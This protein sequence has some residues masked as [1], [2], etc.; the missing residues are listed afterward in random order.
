MSAK[1]NLFLPAGLVALLPAVVCAAEATG[2]RELLQPP[3]AV[4]ASPITDR[5]A[6][7]GIY[8]MPSVDMPM[9]Y[10][11][12]SGV[13]GTPLT[14]EGTLGFDD[15]LNQGSLELMFRMAERHRIRADFYQ[16]KRGGD[17]V[18]GS[19]VQFGENLYLAADR[20]QSSVD[21]RLLGVSY[22]YSVL[23]RERIELGLGFGLNL[24]QAE[25]EARVAQRMMRDEFSVA[26]PFGTLVFDGTWRFTNRFSANLRAQYLSGDIAQVDEDVEGSFSS[27]HADVQFRWRPN[28]AFGLGYTQQTVKVASVDSDFSGRIVL[29]TRGPEAFVRVSF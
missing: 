9:R 15:Q 27:Y 8:F 13:P 19:D 14:G 23:R 25:G 10:D 17:V 11:A 7:R 5:F 21:S 6:L 2:G 16:Q 3:K 24:L 29:K 28:V 12:A 18:L 4:I 20:V 26:G 1:L 22:T